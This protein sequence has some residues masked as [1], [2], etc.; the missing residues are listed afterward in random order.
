[1]ITLR[2]LFLGL[3]ILTGCS[4]DQSD[5]QFKPGFTVT[6]T[7]GACDLALLPPDKK[8]HE[9]KITNYQNL[10]KNNK[11]PLINL[12]KL[13]WAYVSQAR[14]LFDDGYYQFALQTANCIELEQPNSNEA[15][16]LKAY[17]KI[18]LHEFKQAE[19]LA[20]QLI[21]QRGYWFEYGILGDAMMEQG[22]L[23]AAE[24]AYQ[25][26]MNQRPGSQ[27]YTRAAHLRWLTGDLDGAVEMMSMAVKSHRTQKSQSAAWTQTQL[28]FYLFSAKDFEAAEG[29]VNSALSSYENYPPALFL[30]SRL[31]LAKNQPNEAVD[32]LY[33]AIESNPLPQ[34]QW[35]LI[36]IL[37]LI[38]KAEQAAETENQLANHGPVQDP[39]T[40]AL[41]LA[42]NKKQNEF[43]LSLTQAE[44]TKR[45][46]I[47]SHDAMA[48]A[49]YA[50][51][52]ID[53]ALKHINLALAEGTK[54]ARLFFHAAIIN[55]AAG[56][57][58]QAIEWF[59]KTLANKHMLMPSEQQSLM[60]NFASYISQKNP[61][62]AAITGQG[63]TFIKRRTS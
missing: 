20:K 59:K 34:Y 3:L 4:Q 41:Y 29:L 61:L 5:T 54:S 30:K 51:S 42:T 24:Q 48:W 7:A 11:Q 17:V 1:M 45:Q 16:L 15:L 25:T 36:E 8:S 22:N 47:F 39:R 19:D 63:E 18:Q 28:G 14:N 37:R 53:A 50:D 23:I 43:A 38:G 13:G 21:E 10:I 40:Y 26:M 44:L 46:D 49:L 62:K 35:Y 56:N 27:A 58:L 57:N 55:K 2:M 12:E 6:K 52:Q 32:A 31:Y 9:P 33:K 60:T